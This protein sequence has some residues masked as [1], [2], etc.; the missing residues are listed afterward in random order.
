MREYKVIA[1]GKAPKNYEYWED[2]PV[3]YGL[4]IHEQEEAPSD[5]GLI[6]PHGNA[7]FSFPAETRIGFIHF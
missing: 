4:T 3:I 1:K 7:I 2:A 5:T 6:D